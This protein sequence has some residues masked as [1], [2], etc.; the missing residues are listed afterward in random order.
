MTFLQF[1]T[2]QNAF[3][4]YANGIDFSIDYRF[5]LENFGDFHAGL[6]GSE[7][8]RFDQQ[9]GGNGGA[10]AAAWRGGRGLPGGSH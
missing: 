1:Y 2:Q 4:L 9:G 7:K 6:D 3:N 10:G 5:A 8:L